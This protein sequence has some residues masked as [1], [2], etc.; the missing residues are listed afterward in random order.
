MKY[1]IFFQFFMVRVYIYNNALK[2]H[3]CVVFLP[4]HSPNLEIYNELHRN[5]M[6]YFPHN[7]CII[8]VSK[9]L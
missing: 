3:Q 4:D 5:P 6:F 7:V 1:K 9:L 8:H 2:T